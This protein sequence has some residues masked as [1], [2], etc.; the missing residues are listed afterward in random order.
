MTG[1]SDYGNSSD[2]IRHRF[3]GNFVWQMPFFRGSSNALLRRSRGR[4]VVERHRHRPDRQSCQRDHHAR[5]RPIPDRPASGPTRVGPIDAS[6]CGSGAGCLRQQQRIRPAGAIHLRQFRAE[7]FL[8][9]RTCE[10]G[11]RRWRRPSAIHER[12][13]FQFRMDAYNTFNHVNWGHLT[14]SGLRP[15]LAISLRPARCG[16]SR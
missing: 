2:D 4:M 13:A 7:S 15:R 6:S 14:G 10:P 16:R 12:F 5:I 9:S 8:W 1:E 11:L 3:V